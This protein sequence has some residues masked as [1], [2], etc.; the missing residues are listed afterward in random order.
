VDLERIYIAGGIA[1]DVDGFNCGEWNNP[2]TASTMDP[3]RVYNNTP[4]CDVRDMSASHPDR[5]A[6]Q[7]QYTNNTNTRNQIIA[8]VVKYIEANLVYEATRTSNSTILSYLTALEALDL[9]T[10]THTKQGNFFLPPTIAHPFDSNRYIYLDYGLFWR[11]NADQQAG[12]EGVDM[13]GGIGLSLTAS[14]VPSECLTGNPIPGSR[15]TWQIT[16]PQLYH[17][18]VRNSQL[19]F[20]GAG[21]HRNLVN[22]LVDQ[23]WAQQIPCMS[24]WKGTPGMGSSF[25]SILTGSTFKMF[26]PGLRDT[27][28]NR[29][30]MVRVVPRYVKPGD[31]AAAYTANDQP[32]V[33]Y[34]PGDPAWLIAGTGY[35][36][37]RYPGPFDLQVTAPH[38]ELQFL[39]D[40]VGNGQYTSFSRILSID[41]W[42]SL[43]AGIGW[44]RIT[45]YP[46]TLP[47]TFIDPVGRCDL[48]PFPCR[49][50]RLGV[51]FQPGINI[52]YDY[53]TATYF[54]TP[55]LT[56]A[57]AGIIGLLFNGV[58]QGKLEI[59]L[60][61]ASPSFLGVAVDPADPPA[62]GS[63]TLGTLFVPLDLDGDS[64][65]ESLGFYLKMADLYGGFVTTTGDPIAGA[66]GRADAI[67]PK[68]IMDTL[69]NL[70]VWSFVGG[71]P[72][73]Q[74]LGGPTPVSLNYPADTHFSP[75]T[76]WDLPEINRTGSE[77]ELTPEEVRRLGLGEDSVWLNAAGL[78][79]YVSSR[80]MIFHY[81][82]DGGV[83]QI[84]YGGKIR[85]PPL[86]DGQHTIEVQ[87]VD[88]DRY[89]DPTP[90]VLRFTL[91]RFPPMIRFVGDLDR[92]GEKGRVELGLEL[93][94]AVTPRERIRLAY[95]L[96]DASFKPLDPERP[97]ISE[98]VA[99]GEHILKIRAEDES[100]NLATRELRFYA[101]AS[102][103]FG[104]S[105]AGSSS[106]WAGL[107]A[108][109][110]LISASFA[111]LRRRGEA[112]DR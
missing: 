60:N 58:L 19:A 52:V 37:P 39:V 43:Y 71:A 61:T 102:S 89:L 8:E 20:V 64:T 27:Y 63:A 56:R 47:P 107:L 49:V 2:A 50:L 59:A 33:I 36:D 86:F 91:D 87:A 17:T 25:S 109:L 96:D 18:R 82:V 101:S 94:D 103:G 46:S 28:A 23:V 68:F 31:T 12:E 30:M 42:L 7:N 84:G 80:R 29:D 10:V 22:T 62:A 44:Y 53:A 66:D 14:V 13:P 35:P 65:F 97:Y 79:P 54:D 108:L 55:G 34:N 21:L 74:D 95:A 9:R 16:P 24:L 57:I 38:I 45:S 81:R 93:S 110:I 78:T 85:I 40:S 83:Y 72:S 77:I 4:S 15:N 98:R 92:L 73:A 105:L 99:K 5:S 1:L 48:T 70:G 67:S 75:D 112:G 26:L 11:F 90:A 100:G 76:L 6:G 51:A 3:T 104:C 111:L 69:N 32:R 41:A 88:P 106:S